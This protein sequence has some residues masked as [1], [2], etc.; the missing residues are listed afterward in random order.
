MSEIKSPYPNGT[1]SWNDLLTSDRE[2]AVRF[3]GAVLGWEFQVGP[4]ESGYYTMCEVRGLPVAGIGQQPP[5]DPGSPVAWTTY[6]AVDDVDATLDRVKSAGGSVLM[7]PLDVFT[8]GRMAIAADPAGAAFGMW[9]PGNHYGARLVDEPGAPCWH[10][11]LTRDQDAAKE[12]YRTVFGLQP[13]PLRADVDY[14]E[15]RLGD[16]VVAGM[17]GLGEGAAA[18]QPSHW[19]RYFAVPDTDAA[20]QAAQAQGGQLVTG[21]ADSDFGRMAVLSDPQGAVFSVIRLS[22]PPP[23]E[24]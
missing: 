4:P 19:M 20:V 21:P 14:T 15:L 2:A 3:Y 1:P 18:E 9:Q 10:E 6:L 11:V 17:M 13:H 16:R 22:P 5:D 8:E 24:A 23:G 12:F 7:D